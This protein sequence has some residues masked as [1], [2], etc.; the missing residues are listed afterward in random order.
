MFM[1][2]NKDIDQAKDRRQT[3][4]NDQTHQQKP[5]KNKEVLT[6]HD[7]FFKANLSEKRKVVKLIKQHLPEYLV[8]KVDFNESNQLIRGCL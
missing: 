4:Q 1:T 3:K 7:A 5:K 2:K 8:A 6:A